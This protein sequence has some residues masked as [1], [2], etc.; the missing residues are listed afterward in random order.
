MPVACLGHSCPWGSAATGWGAPLGGGHDGGVKAPSVYTVA[1]LLWLLALPCLQPRDG[2]DGRCA[3]RWPHLSHR[4][5]GWLLNGSPPCGGRRRHSGAS[6]VALTFRSQSQSFLELQREL[7]SYPTD[8]H[9]RFGRSHR[10]VAVAASSADGAR[11]VA[12]GASA[13]VF[14]S[15][16]AFTFHTLHI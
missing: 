15:L 9:T 10:V 5:V 8:G 3:R 13:F 11:A 7:H 14:S 16:L 1:A 12:D 2:P 4:T 6:S